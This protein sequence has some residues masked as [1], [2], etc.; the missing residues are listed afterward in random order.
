MVR[1]PSVC[2]ESSSPFQSTEK[3]GFT[4][5]TE[6]DAASIPEDKLDVFIA[7]HTQFSRFKE[8]LLQGYKERIT[9][10]THLLMNNVSDWDLS[11]LSFMHIN[12][13]QKVIQSVLYCSLGSL[14]QKE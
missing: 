6:A 13:A 7:A 2:L 3:C 1:T 5:E 4:F 10:Q 8:M 9:P 12:T 11:K 14:E